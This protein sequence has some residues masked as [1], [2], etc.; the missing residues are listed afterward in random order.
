MIL[1]TLLYIRVSKVCISNT[2]LK[3]WVNILS[4]TRVLS[5]AWVWPWYSTQ[6]L[7][8]L[9]TA[10]DT[11][12]KFWV[13]KVWS[14]ILYSN[15]E[16]QKYD[17]IYSTQVLSKHSKKYSI[18]EYHLGMMSNRDRVGLRDVTSQIMLNI[19]ANDGHQIDKWRNV[20]GCDWVMAMSERSG[21]HQK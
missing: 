14:R 5:I 15:F 1:N 6:F 2:L 17:I 7:S 3:Y 12:L 11:L 4:T 8:R 21:G 13:S 20:T 18:V 9:S 10:W 16:Y 19:S